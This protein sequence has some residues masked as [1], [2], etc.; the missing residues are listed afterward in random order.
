LLETS[1]RIRVAREEREREERRRLEEAERR[2]QR[3]LLQQEEL[4]KVTALENAAMDWHK[5][6]IIRQYI[7]SVEDA[8]Q[9]ELDEEKRARI[10]EWASWGREKADWYDP[11]VA[12]EDPV[13]GKRQHAESEKNKV[14]IK[15]PYSFFR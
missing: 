4:E 2:R 5:A 9:K 14:D 3:A 7:A 12:K 10:T 11:I 6:L 1:E 8:L 15:D 13:L